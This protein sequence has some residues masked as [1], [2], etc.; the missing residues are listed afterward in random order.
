[1]QNAVLEKTQ[2]CEHAVPML[3]HGSGRIILCG[4]FSSDL[5]EDMQKT[6]QERRKKTVADCLRLKVVLKFIFKE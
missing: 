4:S 1:M 3:K 6:G 2:H 5:L